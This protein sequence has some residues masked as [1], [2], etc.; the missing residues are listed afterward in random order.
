M[1][2]V[3]KEHRLLNQALGRYGLY[4]DFNDVMYAESWRGRR[5]KCILVL[6][7]ISAKTEKTAAFS[8]VWETWD[9]CVK[10]LYDSIAQNGGLSCWDNDGKVV[11]IKLP[12]FK[13]A[14]ELLMKIELM[15][16]R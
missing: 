2:D 5:T 13:T 3:Y 10:E 4:V 16:D 8:G 12:A 11:T 15:G 14:R 1:I 9:D 7:R 6:Q